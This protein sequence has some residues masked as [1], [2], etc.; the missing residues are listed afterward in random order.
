MGVTTRR[1]GS[2]P[3]KRPNTSTETVIDYDDFENL[4]AAAKW[5]SSRAQSKRLENHTLTVV[6]SLGRVNLGTVCESAVLMFCALCQCRLSRASLSYQKCFAGLAVA[7]MS[8]IFL[9]S[10]SE[11]KEMGPLRSACVDDLVQECNHSVVNP[12]N[13]ISLMTVHPFSIP[14]E[15]Y[16]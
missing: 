14:K 8:L 10:L 9:G 1:L 2:L 3:Q 7:Y 4:L 16:P 11:C 15:S 12:A 5:P 6:R 13:L